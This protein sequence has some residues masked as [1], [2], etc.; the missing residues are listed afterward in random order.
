M[1]K[2]KLGV[3][4]ELKCIETDSLIQITASFELSKEIKNS[5]AK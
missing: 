1:L 3:H 5:S 2:L 4:S